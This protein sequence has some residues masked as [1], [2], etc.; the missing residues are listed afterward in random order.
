MTKP[1]DYKAVLEDL[2]QQKADLERMIAFTERMLG[3]GGRYGAGGASAEKS[4][5]HGT[6]IQPDTF[7]GKNILQASEKYLRMV[8]RPARSTEEIAEALGRG[9]VTASAGSV[10]T[11]LGRSKNGPIQRVKRG[12]WGLAEWYTGDK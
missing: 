11:I 8:G 12:L 4:E 6:E 3:A 2:K 1:V 5:G 10:A 9:G 7:H